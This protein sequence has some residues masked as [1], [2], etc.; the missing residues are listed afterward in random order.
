MLIPVRRCFS[1]LEVLVTLKT[2]RGW[3][4][5]ELYV[6]R[7]TV[8]GGGGGGEE[9]CD[10]RIQGG[11]QGH[12]LTEKPWTF[13]S[14]PK[15]KGWPATFYSYNLFFKAMIEAPGDIFPLMTIQFKVERLITALPSYRLN[16]NFKVTTTQ[17]GWMSV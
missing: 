14:P 6:R 13:C 8:L 4:R 16:M 3:G 10:W 7:G 9:R 12:T 11:I 2:R 15:K 17:V 5:D 1:A